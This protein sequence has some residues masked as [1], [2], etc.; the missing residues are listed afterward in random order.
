MINSEIDK[1]LDT[2]EERKIQVNLVILIMNRPIFL[3]NIYKIL[4]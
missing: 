1:F 2:P 3:R 4:G